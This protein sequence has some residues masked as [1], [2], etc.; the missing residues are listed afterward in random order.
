MNSIQY[1]DMEVFLYL[2]DSLARVQHHSLIISQRQLNFLGKYTNL[3]MVKRIKVREVS[4]KILK[5]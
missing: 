4:L 1:N 3:R 2:A 5:R